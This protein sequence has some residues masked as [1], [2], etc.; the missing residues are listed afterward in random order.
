M[1]TSTTQWH[2]FGRTE[3]EDLATL[4]NGGQTGWADEHGRPAPWPHDFLDPTA[5]WTSNN[6]QNDAVTT[7]EN[8]P[9]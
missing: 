4:N 5:G 9:F 2:P 1:N 6:G 7:A 3:E 8:P